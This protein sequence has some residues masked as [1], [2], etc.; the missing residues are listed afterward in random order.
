MSRR[1]NKK[2]SIW[3]KIIIFIVVLVL[4]AVI[5]GRQGEE[6]PEE[7]KALR[8]KG[9]VKTPTDLLGA[10]VVRANRNMLAA[11]NIRDLVTWSKG[12][13]NPP[14]KFRTW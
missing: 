11:K 8:E 13:Y 7:T 1:R 5:F 4:F 12:L 9:I 3:P 14:A 6:K 10:D 2:H